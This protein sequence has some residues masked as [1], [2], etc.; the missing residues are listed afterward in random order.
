MKHAMIL[1]TAAVLTFGG[2]GA[3]TAG[4]ANY[5]PRTQ[6]EQYKP[7]KPMYPKS[8][9]EQAR[10]EVAAKNAGAPEAAG[11]GAMMA[12]ALLMLL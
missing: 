9:A 12:I 10:A 11:M 5:E 7:A 1:M 2:L 8:R 4:D 3:A 6:A